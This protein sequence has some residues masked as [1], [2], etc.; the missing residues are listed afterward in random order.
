VRESTGWSYKH[1]RD[2]TG[3]EDGTENPTLFDAPAAALVPDGAPGAG[4]S[5]LL[6]QQWRHRSRAWRALPE[7][8]QEAVIGRTKPESV[9]LDDGVMPANAHVA[10]TKVVVDDAELPIF[11]RSSPYGTVTEHGLLF[12]GFAGEQRR[13]QTMLEQMAGIGGPRDALTRFSEP[14][15]GAY[16]FCPALSALDAFRTVDDD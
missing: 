4:G 8:D 9:E 7:G 2:L 3:F 12:L 16:Y 6:F 14:L 13:L 10:R 15:T 11:R 1:S 5:V